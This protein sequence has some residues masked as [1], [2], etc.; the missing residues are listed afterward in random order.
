[1]K[2]I[3]RR[4]LAGAGLHVTR[5][6]LRNRFDATSDALGL[7]RDGGYRPRVVID[8]GANVGAW[9]AAARRHFPDA[10]YHLI[11]PQPACGPAL[12]AAAL[13]RD[14]VHA[15][16]VTAPGTTRVRMVGGGPDGRGTGARVSQSEGHDDEVVVEAVTLDALLLE[17]VGPG[18]RALLKLDL[19]GHELSALRGASVLLERVEVLIAEVQF[20]EIEGNGMP[21]FR[22]LLDF[23]HGAGFGLHDIAAMAGRPRDRRLRQGDVVFVSRSSP[24]AQDVQ[25][26]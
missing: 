14:R 2:T 7:M 17:H 10:V 18:D 22:D 8:A 6:P 4:L 11:E 16:A 25:W 1:M 23:L 15:V 3:A 24:L 21:V 19:E 12:A 9:T 5:S 13:P 20:Y 26:A